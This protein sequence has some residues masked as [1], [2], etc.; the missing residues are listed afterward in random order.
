MHLKSFWLNLAEQ[1]ASY[2]NSIQFSSLF[3]IPTFTHPPTHTSERSEWSPCAHTWRIKKWIASLVVVILSSSRQTDTVQSMNSLVLFS[4][5]WVVVCR[6]KTQLMVGK[7][8]WGR[9]GD[10][11]RERNWICLSLAVMSSILVLRQESRKCKSGFENNNNIQNTVQINL[12]RA[13]FQFG[14]ISFHTNTNQIIIK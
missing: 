7:E 14:V 10:W 1:K 9:Q 13:I 4:Y 8:K 12:K 6:P 2:L 3:V 11:K 5:K